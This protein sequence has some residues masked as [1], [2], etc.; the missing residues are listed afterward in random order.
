MM[1]NQQQQQ[2]LHGTTPR[3]PADGQAHG[4][5][6]GRGGGLSPAGVT[7]LPTEQLTQK[8]KFK[9]WIGSLQQQQ[10]QQQ[11]LHHHF[12]QQPHLIYDFSTQ[13]ANTTN[14]ATMVV[15]PQGYY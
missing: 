1:H 15:H 11:T 7:F 12:M 6:N 14:E 9:L 13:M 10:Q 3:P 5:M 4:P 8:Q 2:Q